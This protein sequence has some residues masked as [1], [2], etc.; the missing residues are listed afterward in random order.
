MLFSFNKVDLD[1]GDSHKVTALHLAAIRNQTECA[2][3]LMKNGA[4]RNL[5]DADGDTP[6]HW[7][8][9]K[10]NM[11]V[12]NILIDYQNLDQA[13]DA[14][15][16]P[17]HRASFNTRIP[18]CEVLLKRGASLLSVNK[19]GNTPLHL[20]CASNHMSTVEYLLT[21]GAKLDLANHKG[22]LPA[23]MCGANYASLVADMFSSHQDRRTKPTWNKQL[24][25]RALARTS[26]A[27]ERPASHTEKR[28][29]SDP[30][31]PQ[32]PRPKSPNRAQSFSMTSYSSFGHK[33]EQGFPLIMESDSIQI[34]PII[35]QKQD[36]GAF[37]PGQLTVRQGPT[38]M[39]VA[40]SIAGND[41]GGLGEK[42]ESMD[43]QDMSPWDSEEDKDLKDEEDYS[44]KVLG[45]QPVDQE[46]RNSVSFGQ[47]KRKPSLNN[48]FLEKYNLQ[49]HHLFGP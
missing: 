45:L 9:T 23:E 44:Q 7:A 46:K 15:W 29:A 27:P 4:A 21:W 47:P 41:A 11:E 35:E 8:A 40:G 12:M 42:E 5:V 17:L 10:G 28:R 3:Y 32:S 30:E 2:Q 18:A 37:S 39:D 34:Q 38:A 33:D 22:Q 24:M 31:H 49:K 26:V 43:V 13:N 20:A 19:E 36:Y 48:K 1:A 6:L 14:G 25:R 16:T